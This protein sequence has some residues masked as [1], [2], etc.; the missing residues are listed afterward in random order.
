[1]KD[2]EELPD[3]DWGDES[4]MS[5]QEKWDMKY[6]KYLQYKIKFYKSRL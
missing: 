3:I 4:Q 5:E 1:M 2:N 6:Y